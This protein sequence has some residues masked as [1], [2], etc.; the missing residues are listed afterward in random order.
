M[1]CLLQDNKFNA[2]VPVF[3]IICMTERELLCAFID[4]VAD[5]K[6]EK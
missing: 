3:V 2:A 4:L 5:T 6:A 1:S